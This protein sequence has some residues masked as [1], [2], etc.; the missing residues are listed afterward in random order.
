MTTYYDFTPNAQ[1]P[2]Q[3]Q[4]TLDGQTYSAFVTWSLFGQRY[5]LN[6]YDLSGNPIVALPSIGSPT[7]KALGGANWSG[8]EVTLGTVNPHFF[9]IG[10]TLELTVSGMTPDAYNGT[11]S[12]LA[13]SPNEL[14]YPLT[15][16]PGT[17]TTLGS[18]GMNVNLVG[19][20]FST[21]TLVFRESTN[22][23]EVAP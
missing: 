9:K 10:T 8:G 16:D 11:F 18:V 22:Q 23:F 13:V 7:A 20:Y 12:M 21:S 19:G 3:F 2:F 6:L 1:A 17:P 14:T 15:S 4:P 5:Y